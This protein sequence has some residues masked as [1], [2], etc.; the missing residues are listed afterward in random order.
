MKITP[1]DIQQQQFKKTRGKYDAGEVDSF[2]E[3]IRI[4]MEDILREN[5][6][7]KKELKKTKSRLSE[8]I[9]HE[10][11]LKD[12]IISTQRV[13]EDIKATAHKEADVI[14]AEAKLDSDKLI[15][16]AHDQIKKLADDINELR[17]QRIRVEAEL[18]SILT[19]H[20][21]LLEAASEDAKRL[22]DDINKVTLFSKK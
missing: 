5:D 10:K 1:L 13:A 2:L 9:E 15:M 3:M 18:S 6:T 21:K 11:T 14:I 22:E 8:L 16:N 17:R 7:F 19:A 4:E 20:T 12:A